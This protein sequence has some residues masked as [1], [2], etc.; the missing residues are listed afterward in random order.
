MRE[1]TSTAICSS[2]FWGVVSLKCSVFNAIKNLF[3]GTT[4]VKHLT[5]NAWTKIWKMLK[6]TKLL[7][8]GV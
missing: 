5:T 1:N 4:A 6:L 2:L 8:E 7:S 3:C